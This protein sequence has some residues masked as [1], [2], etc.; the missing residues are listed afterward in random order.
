M[1]FSAGQSETTGQRRR[2]VDG[3]PTAIVTCGA[4][5]NL[6]ARIHCEPALPNGSV[7]AAS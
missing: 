5:A 1:D 2:S 6:G 3:Y 7:H 4:A